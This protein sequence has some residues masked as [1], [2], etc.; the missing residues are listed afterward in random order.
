MS[1]EA[2]R[3][4]A[5]RDTPNGASASHDSHKFTPA[6]RGP[7]PVVAGEG[8]PGATSAVRHQGEA[9]TA[10]ERA[11]LPQEPVTARQPGGGSEG[12]SPVAPDSSGAVLRCP[13]CGVPLE[14]G[15]DCLANPREWPRNSDGYPEDFSDHPDYPEASHA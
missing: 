9:G 4:R 5:S 1:G 11:V 14:L 10:Q 6:D 12:P 2:F 7:Y 15:H 13:E 8:D 3:E